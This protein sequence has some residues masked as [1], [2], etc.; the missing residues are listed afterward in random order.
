VPEDY[1]I[2]GFFKEIALGEY[3][4][5][6]S[7]DKDLFFYNFEKA[8]QLINLSSFIMKDIHGKSARGEID[9]ENRLI[10]VNL[11]YR[12]D[13]NSLIMEWESSYPLH[14]VYVD[15]NLQE[16]NESINQFVPE[17]V[18]ELILF[19]SGE[20]EELVYDFI[21]KRA[22][23]TE[24]LVK[25]FIVQGPESPENFIGKIDNLNNEIVIDLGEKFSGSSLEVVEISLSEGASLNKTISEIDLLGY[26]VHIFVFA[27]DGINKKDYT[28]EV[29]IST[30]SL[31]GTIFS[32]DLFG[33]LDIDGSGK[34]D[35]LSDGIL[36]KR[37]LLGAR[38]E[39]L[40]NQA[41]CLGNGSC[42]EASAK[43]FQE[44]EDFIETN[45]NFYDF[46]GNGVSGLD[47]ANIFLQY[48]LGVL[49]QKSLEKVV[50]YNSKRK[51][52][53]EIVEYIDK[54]R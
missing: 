35:A 3:G 54:L 26:Y 22:P 40:T 5:V 49:N 8:S 33:T 23:N 44:V 6:V 17:E 31:S 50:R 9:N 43:T 29:N 27:E 52:Y 7:S 42:G 19:S 15:G 34:V 46:D 18:R 53:D 39:N 51:S 11:P 4:L 48:A 21:V 32:E 10:E 36:L 30:S 20:T 2:S 25:D 1:S 24:C 38:G 14:S 28:V 16:N 45:L 37:Y 41:L 12:T 47:D 13:F